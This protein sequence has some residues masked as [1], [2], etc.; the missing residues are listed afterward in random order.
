MYINKIGF[1]L[2]FLCLHLIGFAQ[3]DYRFGYPPLKTEQIDNPRYEKS[4]YFQFPSPKQLALVGR[5]VVSRNGN[6]TVY[7]NLT[8]QQVL[9]RIKAKLKEC[10]VP[11]KIYQFDV[12][13]FT[14]KIADC[15]INKTEE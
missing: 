4:E 14:L 15:P 8:Y 7:D 13:T 1:I 3:S 5:N 9:F 11:Y 10:D 12:N 6:Y 2:M